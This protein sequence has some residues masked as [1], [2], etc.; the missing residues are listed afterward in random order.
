MSGAAAAMDRMYRRQ[1]HV[2]DLT[3]KYY[4]LGR[5]RLIIGLRARPGDRVLEIG[6]GTGRNLILAAKTFPHARFHGIDVSS[7]ML[8][9]AREAIARAGVAARVEVALADATSFDPQALFGIASFERIFI[10]YTLSMIPDW[11]AVLDQAMT[12]LSPGGT[13]HVVDFGGQEGWPGWF[14]V[15][16]RRWLRLFHVHPR[17]RLEA[18]LADL[19]ALTG[20]TLRFERPMRG[21]AQHAV[22][23]LAAAAA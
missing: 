9:T 17:R 1:R 7:E 14:R 22:V 23:T 6:C 21:Y 4:L 16:L 19:C 20:A 3:R 5:D 8:V 11:T 15:A 12:R 13:L 2:Y 10:S 18:R